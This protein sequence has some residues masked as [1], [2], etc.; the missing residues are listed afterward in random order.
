MARNRRDI[1]RPG[2]RRGSWVFP[3]FL[4]LIAIGAFFV[5]FDSDT[6]Y[7]AEKE[8][9]D[10]LFL[11]EENK[12]FIK[13]I[14]SLKQDIKDK[15]AD[16]DSY[17]G[18]VETLKQDIV[19]LKS[20]IAVLNKE[21]RSRKD[22]EYSE[23]NN[24]IRNSNDRPGTKLVIPETDFSKKERLIR[25]PKVIYPRRALQRGITGEVSLLYD[26]SISG[27]PYNIRVSSS[28]SSTLNQ[29]AIKAV[30]QMLY[31]PALN[32]RGQKVPSRDLQR[33]IRFTIQD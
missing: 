15:N 6:F 19:S 14:N 16:I 5:L 10:K 13:E 32:K 18:Y 28:S 2:E 27:E 11:L 24:Q 22:K 31:E 7:L 9:E 3:F 23:A 4:T 17:K 21:T 12:L 30:Q 33:K 20:E 29:A 1:R 26:V 8:D 25:G